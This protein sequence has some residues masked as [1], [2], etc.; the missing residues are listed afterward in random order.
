MEGQD[1]HWV[2]EM[3]RDAS[4][5]VEGEIPLEKTQ[6]VGD[7]MNALYRSLRDDLGFQHEQA[8]GAIGALA[9]RAIVLVERHGNSDPV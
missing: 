7:A 4:S 5:L 9:V 3:M 1:G 8:M 6:A 2:G